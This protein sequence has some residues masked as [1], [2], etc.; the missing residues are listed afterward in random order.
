MLILDIQNQ[1]SNMLFTDRTGG[2]RSL[3]FDES[4]RT[5]Y[6]VRFLQRIDTPKGLG[7]VLGESDGELWFW[8]DNDKGV[9]YWGN[10]RNLNTGGFRL[11]EDENYPEQVANHISKIFNVP[12]N[13]ILS[14]EKMKDDEYLVA[15]ALEKERDELEKVLNHANILTPSN[16]SSVLQ[17]PEKTAIIA[18]LNIFFSPSPTHQQILQLNLELFNALL[19]QPSL[20]E[21][22]ETFTLLKK[23][24]LLNE[25]SILSLLTTG[26]LPSTYQ[27][28]LDKFLVV[29]RRIKENGTLFGN[30][31]ANLIELDTICKHEQSKLI[32]VQVPELFP[33]DDA[34]IQQHLNT[35][36]PNWR[37]LWDKFVQT[38]K[39]MNTLNGD[40]L[41]QLKELQNLIIDCFKKY[42]FNTVIIQ[43][44]QL[45]LDTLFMVRSTG[46]EDKVDLA[47][48]GGNKSVAAVKLDGQAFS[49]AIGT[50]VASYFSAKSLTQRLLSHDDIT[51]TPFMP[52]L[53]QKMVGEK[54]NG[55][56]S[57]Q[58][59]ISGVMYAKDNMTR[60]EVAPGHGELIVNSK[61][62]FDTY[63]V[64]AEQIVH[65]EIRK[66]EVRLVPVEQRNSRR[67]L[68]FK[69]NSKKIQEM[70][71]L[72]PA[73]AKEIGGIGQKIAAHY[74]MPMDIEFVYEPST[75]IL[76]LVQTRPIPQDVQHT[77]EPSSIA[78]EHWAQIKQNHDIEK[79][80]VKVI[81]PAGESVQV[82]TDKDQILFKKGIGKAL[83]VYL[84]KPEM[85]DKIRAIMVEEDAPSTSHEAAQF[86]ALGL[87]V[88]QL[89][90]QSVN[91]WLKVNKPVMIIDPQRQHVINWTT[92]IKDH[93]N[94]EQELRDKKIVVAGIF[95]SSLNSNK[96][97]LPIDYQI[98]KT[99]DENIQKY[100]KN[101]QE[102]V[103]TK[104]IY[105]N[106][107]HYFEVLESAKPH[108]EN[109]EAFQALRKIAE[110]FKALGTSTQAN[111]DN[112]PH[113]K[114]FLHAMLSI[115]EID[116][117]LDKY[118]TLSENCISAVAQQHHLLALISKLKALTVAPGEKNIYSDSIMQ[119][120]T[121]N[122]IFSA[123]NTNNELTKDQQEYFQE[124]LK[125][126]T[127]A[128]RQDTR[129]QWKQF[130]YHCSKSPIHRQLLA[131]II[132]QISHYHLESE[133]IN[134]LFLRHLNHAKEKM[135]AQLYDTVLMDM[136]EEVLASEKQIKQ[137]QFNENNHRITCW[138]KKI[139]EWSNPSKF[140]HLFDEFEREILP[141]ISEISIDNAMPNLMKK[142]VLKQAQNLTELIDKTIKSMKGSPEYTKNQTS[143]LIERFIKLLKPYH[144]LM[145]IW[146]ETI[147]EQQYAAWTKRISGDKSYNFK[148][149]MITK[150]NY[151]FTEK[152]KQPL[153][154]PKELRPSGFIS[155]SSARVGTTASFE[156]QF[157]N[158]ADKLS[159]E[160]LFSLFHQ[161]ILAS[162]VVIGKD[163]EIPIAH[164]PQ[165]LQPLLQVLQADRTIDLLGYRHEP[166]S[167][168]LEYN[169]PMDNHSAKLILEYN[170]NTQTLM[171]H[172]NFFGR[173]WEDRMNL[174][175][176]IAAMEAMFLNSKC[177]SESVFNKK[178][179][180]LNF[181]WI[182]ESDQINRLVKHV[183]GIIQHYSS[184][185]EDV[186]KK[187]AYQTILERYL[188]SETA[189]QCINSLSAK[190]RA[191]LTKTISSIDKDILIN[192]FSIKDLNDITLMHLL[193]DQGVVFQIELLNIEC[194]TSFMNDTLFKSMV[195]QELN[196]WDDDQLA[197]WF[198]SELSDLG[199]R[200]IAPDFKIMEL[201]KFIDLVNVIKSRLDLNYRDRRKEYSIF[202][203]MLM[204]FSWENEQDRTFFD[205]CEIDFAQ[206]KKA[207]SLALEASHVKTAE[208]LIEK[209]SP[210]DSLE[211][212]AFMTAANLSMGREIL[213][214]IF[215]TFTPEKLT[216]A[217]YSEYYPDIDTAVPDLDIDTGVMANKFYNHVILQYSKILNFNFRRHKE[218]PSFFEKL[219]ELDDNTALLKEIIAKDQFDISQHPNAIYL[220]YLKN[221]S[222]IV[223]L[224]ARIK[225]DNFIIMPEDLNT[226]YKSSSLSDCISLFKNWSK[227]NLSFW[228]TEHGQGLESTL[229]H[230]LQTELSSTPQTDCLG[231]K[232]AFTNN[233]PMQLK[234]EI[235]MKRSSSLNSFFQ[236]PK[237]VDDSTI[238][239]NFVTLSII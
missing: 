147:P 120:A 127:L 35:Y 239:N 150:I 146:M 38:Q 176:N 205:N 46:D 178:N 171:L 156:R 18:L 117:C 202:E 8:L 168:Y 50:V 10:L 67:K 192:L 37:K 238:E 122:K 48:P 40:A 55:N 217:L 77:I 118:S 162:L 85:Q 132:M 234:D 9:S 23:I 231:T 99:I 203:L 24:N 220:A 66:K 169:I 14:I 42:T 52:V 128:L 161:N 27:K 222:D 235:S 11:L 218:D 5:R 82:I 12:L 219:I 140:D 237:A 130:S 207:V 172:W 26:S 187:T 180:S 25:E 22:L 7:T 63:D 28:V 163:V 15:K 58:I 60:I 97:L 144:K 135:Q 71:S 208:W 232:I 141:L 174:I 139:N 186:R 94:A 182:F 154:D 145:Q 76:Y 201:V 198:H 68:I 191:M 1:K 211:R 31:A 177:L 153:Y 53:I 32:H 64:T 81:S 57:N 29:Q 83:K 110:I 3:C 102:K 101:S 109:K 49:E 152:C 4:T 197:D 21:I 111:K 45:P 79:I 133:L 155:V 196:N 98:T 100:L 214:K 123:M 138:E 181:S 95:S 17:H 227:K 233:V 70:P 105:T 149:P 230:A 151:V 89:P 188:K 36:A 56:D 229:L 6:G 112:S 121:Q 213:L 137:S 225:A 91:A 113:K 142:A 87:P 16:L 119:I 223:M 59:I 61:A 47:N 65:A 39:E 143:L 166:P 136:F 193:L 129:D 33:I 125:L 103:D 107:I 226:L 19:N 62:P 184:L 204:R 126:N 114:I 236:K 90:L 190:N 228:M 78:P 51:K 34:T 43:S 93:K 200:S 72:A 75:Q 116:Q 210:L 170:T 221:K 224:L 199:W 209:G 96:T 86:N 44:I 108:S 54:L 148:E 69:N 183:N 2:N 195:N 92:Q 74:G 179:L 13:V 206:Q 194:I 106:L 115:A 160:D 20:K 165:E 104:Y 134:G 175:A 30:K 124:F 185:T 84:D 164:L 215:N 167:V 88:L 216:D 159:M 80:K 212:N 158:Q 157:V 73:I 131:K 189:P 41:N 173:N